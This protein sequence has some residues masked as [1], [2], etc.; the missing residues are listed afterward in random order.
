MSSLKDFNIA[1]LIRLLYDCISKGIESWIGYEVSAII[2]AH[3]KAIVWN[4][5]EEAIFN[6]IVEV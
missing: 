2:E 5:I 3:S 4:F 6:L 1:F